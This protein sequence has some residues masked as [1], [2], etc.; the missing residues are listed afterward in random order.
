MCVC[1][2]ISH[3]TQSIQPT[4]EYINEASE[5][6]IIDINYLKTYK[7]YVSKQRQNKKETQIRNKQKTTQTCVLDLKLPFQTKS[8]TAHNRFLDLY[9]MSNT[10]A[11]KPKLESIT[12][13]E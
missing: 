10:N 4:K 3:Q 13:T 5:N 7:P 8:K 1:V 9:P 2:Y 12:K 6:K 11:K